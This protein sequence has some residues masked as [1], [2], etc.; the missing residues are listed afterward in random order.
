MKSVLLLTMCVSFMAM[1]E[2]IE[3]GLVEK[4][5]AAVKIQTNSPIPIVTVSAPASADQTVKSVDEV[6]LTVKDEVFVP[7]SWLEDAVVTAKQ[8]PVIGPFV[9]I[10]FK[11][12]G[13]LVAI[14]TALFAF[15]WTVLK[16]LQGVANSTSLYGLSTKLAGIEN[17]KVMYYLKAFSA[18][19]AQKTDKPE[20]KA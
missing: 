19:N 9:V 12:L 1:A 13:L 6:K 2:N 11:W 8:L 15:L 14:T 3:I 16:S 4:A 17:S 20:S 18:F 10:V 5:P 7:P